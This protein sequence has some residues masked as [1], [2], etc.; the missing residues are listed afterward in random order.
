MSDQPGAAARVQRAERDGVSVSASVLEAGLDVDGRVIDWL[1]IDVVAEGDHRVR[2][3][4]A[5]GTSFTLAKLGTTHDRFMA[6]LR[7]RRRVARFAALTVATGAPLSSYLSRAADGLVDVHLYAKVLVVEPRLG[8][9]TAAPLPL[10]ERVDRDG[11]DITISL[12]G[13]PPVHVSALGVKTDEFLRRLAAARQDLQ[14]A[15]SAA[16]AQYDAAL[17]GLSAPDGW[18]LTAGTAGAHWPALLARATSGSRSAEVQFLA[19]RAGAQLAVGIFT[20]GGAST[21]PFVLAPI[22]GCVVVEATDGDDRATYVF[23]A[24]DVDRLNSVLILTGFRREALFLPDDQLGRWAIAARLWPAVR[25]AR[26]ALVGRVVHGERWQEQV[27]AVLVR[28]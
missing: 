26:A 21:L 12:R 6:E 9:P 11:Y 15:T 7:E 24:D 25:E 2:L 17:N 23:R 5:D 1:D 3:D 22:G 14:V 20:D 27:E 4:L 8:H 13:L 16:Y 10:I 28:Q 18:A 19:G